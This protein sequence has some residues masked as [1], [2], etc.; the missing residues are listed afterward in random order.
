M[1]KQ[2]LGEILYLHLSDKDTV[3]FQ[4]FSNES[5]MS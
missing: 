2:M 4:Y 3:T 1:Q 5:I